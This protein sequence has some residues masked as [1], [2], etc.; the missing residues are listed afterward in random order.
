[1]LTIFNESA[2]GADKLLLRAA[3]LSKLA[4]LTVS[5]D[6]NAEVEDANASTSR[7][8]VSACA[9]PGVHTQLQAYLQDNAA[10]APRF[11]TAL[12]MLYMLFA[13]ENQPSSSAPEERYADYDRALLAM[14]EAWE[15][16][17]PALAGSDLLLRLLR[18]IPRVP[19]TIFPVRN[20]GCPLNFN[21]FQSF[22]R[23]SLLL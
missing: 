23:C 22:N 13:S 16:R 8:I 12:S 21:I 4:G 15:K 7:G 14:C 19:S 1:M 5:S 17:M 6:D 11:E 3:Y 20:L 9:I 10:T 18:E 2:E